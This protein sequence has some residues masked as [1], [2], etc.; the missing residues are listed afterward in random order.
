MDHKRL[1]TQNAPINQ[2]DIFMSP[3]KREI[4]DSFTLDELHEKV[5]LTPEEVE[6]MNGRFPFRRIGHKEINGELVQIIE[7]LYRYDKEESEKINLH[8]F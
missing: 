7:E 1:N 2:E 4:G 5:I 8:H 6:D 3:E